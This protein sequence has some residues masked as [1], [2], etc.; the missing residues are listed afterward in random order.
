[1]YYKVEMKLS[2]AGIK[3]AKDKF[4]SLGVKKKVVVYAFPIPSTYYYSTD[5]LPL[6]NPAGSSTNMMTPERCCQNNVLT[7]YLG[8]IRTWNIPNCCQKF[9][10]HI[11]KYKE[12]KTSF[13]HPDRYT[14]RRLVW[15]CIRYFHSSVYALMRRC[16]FSDMIHVSDKLWSSKIFP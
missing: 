11:K 14:P 16:M 6:Q 8:V 3:L 2:V 4:R 7:R 12:Y 5:R 15:A 9:N 1:M 10:K 13:N